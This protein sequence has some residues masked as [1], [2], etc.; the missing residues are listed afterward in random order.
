MKFAPEQKCLDLEASSEDGVVATVSTNSTFDCLK[1][2]W[3]I[4]K[5]A[6]GQSAKILSPANLVLY[7]SRSAF[8]P[9]AS[10]CDGSVHYT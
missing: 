4:R 6:R 9:A 2:V 1:W 5:F 10:S 3:L 7:G 8:I